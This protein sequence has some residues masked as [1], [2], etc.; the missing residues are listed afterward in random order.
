MR[1][2]KLVTNE[3]DAVIMEVVG[4]ITDFLTANRGMNNGYS[5]YVSGEVEVDTLQS[6]Q[7]SC[8][9]MKDLTGQQVQDKGWALN[10]QIVDI[11]KSHKSSYVSKI[12]IYY[13][14]I[15]HGCFHTWV[16]VRDRV[17]VQCS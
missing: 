3:V 2:F 6:L 9:G 17:R 14:H 12:W 13:E 11:L 10:Q 4:A 16:E 5:T 15:E 7:W 1:A 8:P